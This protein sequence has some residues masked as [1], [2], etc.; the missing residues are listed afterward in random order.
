[1]TFLSL[2]LS[3]L[4]PSVYIEITGAVG[5]TPSSPLMWIQGSVNNA[6]SGVSMY[7]WNRVGVS[8]DGISSIGKSARPVSRMELYMSR[9]CP[10]I[11]VSG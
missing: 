10:S 9:V 7:D 2:W 3:S 5:S 11:G 6:G 1:M 4:L 8:V